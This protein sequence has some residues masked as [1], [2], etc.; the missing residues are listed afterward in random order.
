[1]KKLLFIAIMLYSHQMLFAQT[2]ID[3]V[4][5]RICYDVRMSYYKKRKKQMDEHRLDIGKNG[6]SRYYSYW[7]CLDQELKDS[8]H[9]VGGNYDDYNRIK[10]EKGYPNSKFAYTIF[11]NYQKAYQLTGICTPYSDGKFLFSEEMGQ[12]WNLVGDSVYKVLDHPCR[13]ATARFHGREWIAY[14]ATDIPI[15][16]GPWKLCGLPGLIMFARDADKEYIFKCMAIKTHVNEPIVI[17]K[18]DALEVRPQKLEKLL[19]DYYSN[20]LGAMNARLGGMEATFR[21]S[22]GQVIN[23]QT[24]KIPEPVLLDYY[25]QNEQ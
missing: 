23:P 14:Y 25:G 6:I 9:A 20:P 8:V 10:R 22:K 11:K 2:T 17:D 1:M 24:M 13:K 15:P 7:K 4:D 3:S 5:I 21:D 12:Q 16:E 19:R 18:R